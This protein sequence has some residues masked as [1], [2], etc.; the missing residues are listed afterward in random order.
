MRLLFI[1]VLSSGFAS[2]LFAEKAPFI[3]VDFEALKPVKVTR[4]MIEKTFGPL[5]WEKLSG[6]A[7]IKSEAAE[8]CLEVSYPKGQFGSLKSGA[9]FVVQLQESRY[10]TLSYRFRV[11]EDFTFVKGGKLPGLSGGGSQFTGGRRPGSEGGWS[12]RYMW[13]REGALELY[14]YHP[15]M[16]EKY[17]ERHPLGL[18]LK[19]GKWYSITQKID[20]GEPGKAQGILEVAVN[21]EVKLRLD[22]LEFHGSRFGP[23]DSFLFSTFYG[24]ADSS[25]APGKEVEISFDDFEI[26]WEKPAFSHN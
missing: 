3:V 16:K 17:G 1:F 13:R 11:C 14:L 25:W 19:R 5:D 12:A 8:R 22:R 15:K 20:T 9:Q 18:K 10:A 24:G 21:G 23:I 7:V 26:T 6:R 4:T 2:H